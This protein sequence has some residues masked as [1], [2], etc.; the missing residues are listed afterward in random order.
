[1]VSIVIY[2]DYIQR[3]GNLF[4][5][6][7]NKFGEICSGGQKSYSLPQELNIRWVKSMVIVKY[8]KDMFISYYVLLAL[9]FDMTPFNTLILFK[10]QHFLPK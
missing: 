6:G 2:A 5:F 1:M 4:G 7:Q 9:S 3:K 8:N 10:E